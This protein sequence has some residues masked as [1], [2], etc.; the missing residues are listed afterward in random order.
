MPFQGRGRV[1][2]SQLCLRTG[3]LYCSPCL[4]AV[5]RISRKRELLTKAEAESKGL[6]FGWKAKS[7]PYDNVPRLIVCSII[8]AAAVLR[9]TITVTV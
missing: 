8:R 5:V 3:W 2:P 7:E 9:H 1:A 4:S 6:V